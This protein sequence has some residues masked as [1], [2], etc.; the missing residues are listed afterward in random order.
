MPRAARTPAQYPCTSYPT[1]CC[2]LG[3]AGDGF[4]TCSLSMHYQHA[5]SACTISMHYR[6]A[7]SACTISMHYQHA[8]SACTIGMH[9]HH[10]YHHP[11]SACT[12]SMHYQHALSAC[13][14]SI[15]I[16]MHYRHAPSACTISMHIEH[17]P[18]ASLSSHSWQVTTV[19]KSLTV[20]LSFIAFP[21]PWS[22]KYAWGGACLAIAI[23][24][25][26]HA[27]QRRGG[28]TKAMPE[29]HPRDCGISAKESDS[30]DPDEGHPLW[31]ASTDAPGVRS[32]CTHGA[33]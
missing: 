4:T 3:C 22:S 6:H 7:L 29:S 23:S 32:A 13:T 24:L 9:Y 5:L 28:P 16:S 17:A 26:A 31:V 20:I 1:L 11:L 18:Q 12:I 14:I 21:K 27:Y 33:R 19:R 25:D 15:T 10:H 30:S 2:A 8:L